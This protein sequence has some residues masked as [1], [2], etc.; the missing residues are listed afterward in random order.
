MATGESYRALLARSEGAV[1]EATWHDPSDLTRLSR[2]AIA[3]Q[4]VGE[5]RAVSS[6][7][8]LRLH[9]PGVQAES[10]DLEAVGLIAGAWQRTVTAVGAALEDVK[11]ARG[12]VPAHLASRTRLVLTSAPGA[13]S[14]VLS[15]EPRRS[16]VD[17]VAPGGQFPMF[18]AERPLADRASEV[19]IDLCST[20]AEAALSELDEFGERLRVLGP[21][22]A[23]SLRT[24]SDALVHAD[25]ALDSA[26]REPGSPTVRSDLS[27]QSA[28]WL[29]DF[30]DGRELDAED[31]TIEGVAITVSN[32]ER[33]LIETVE[34]AAKVRATDLDLT[35]VRR[36]RPGDFVRLAVRTTMKLQPD[37]TSQLKHHALEVLLVQDSESERGEDSEA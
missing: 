4:Q 24:L 1:P 13:G 11:T 14:L 32:R 15:L 34:G 3:L 28:R 20:A 27:V 10:A 19:L 36:V 16:G 30:I 2:E 18:G 35:D 17:E 22:V 31:G 21:R 7:G 25:V 37:G 26:W 5:V 9:G 6:S 33:W 12:R 23:S 8:H 29:R